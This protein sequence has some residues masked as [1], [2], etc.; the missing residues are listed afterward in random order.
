MVMTIKSNIPGD[1]IANPDGWNPGFTMDGLL[2]AGLFG[3]SLTKNF[4]P[5]GGDVAVVG[6]PVVT[7]HFADFTGS[8]YIDTGISTTKNATLITVAKRKSGAARQYL[9]SCF[10]GGE[11]IG[12]SLVI[13][14]GTASLAIYSH[15]K[16]VNA[17][18]KTV[19]TAFISTLAL[20]GL[21]GTPAFLSARDTGKTLYTN[22]K[23]SNL[24][25]SATA[26]GTVESFADA[27][28]HYRI[29]KSLQTAASDPCSIG[30]AL[31]YNRSLSD[32]ELNAVYAYFQ[33]YFSRR[34][35]SI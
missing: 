21:D 28:L 12:R 4:A 30:A 17:G 2:Y 32:E 11:N 29:G 1:V 22:D 13:E 15:Y 19:S 27:A 25:S 6:S 18:G 5:G 10:Q 26:S 23:T 14:D 33:G 7:G 9:I 16:G 3:R 8:N 34:A 20:T 35:I 24:V 31:I